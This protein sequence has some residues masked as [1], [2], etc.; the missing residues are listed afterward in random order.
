[1]LASIRNQF[2]RDCDDILGTG[3]GSG[4]HTIYIDGSQSVEVYCDME[5]DGI[6]YTVFQNRYDGSVDFYNA[7]TW[8]NYKYGFG[9]LSGEFWLGL[10]YIYRMTM[11]DNYK[12]RVDLEDNN[13][14]KV[15]AE[16]STFKLNSEADLYRLIIAG[17]SGTAGN[18]NRGMLYNQNTQFSSPDNATACTSSRKGGWWYSG[19]TYANLNGL[20]KPGVSSWDSMMWYAFKNIDGCKTTSMKLIKKK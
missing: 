19:C 9:N 2:V 16:Y 20:Y 18:I 4:V 1:M 5:T 14:T 15:Y 11:N 3:Q 6:G 17:E 13:G 7:R 12:L 8:T 10:E